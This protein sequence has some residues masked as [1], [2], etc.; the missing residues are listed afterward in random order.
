MNE[1]D[2]DATATRDGEEKIREHVRNAQDARLPG[3]NGSNITLRRYDWFWP[4]H[5]P[6]GKTSEV[7]GDPAVYKTGTTLY[8]CACVTTGAPFPN[9]PATARR[10]PGKVLFFSAE[11]DDHDTLLPRFLAAGGDRKKIHFVTPVDDLPSLPEDAPKLREWIKAWEPLLVVFDP[12]DAFFGK[13]VDAN[14]NPDVRRALRPL[15]RLGSQTHTTFLLIRHLNKDVKLGRAMYRAAGS[16]GTTAT[17]RASYILGPQRDDPSTYIFACNK[18]NGAPKPRSLGY[19]IVGHVLKG[20]EKD[21]VT[22]R[23]EWLGETDQ[24]ADDLVREPEPG[25][26]GPKPE[27]S[28]SAESIIKQELADGQWHPS[29]PIIELAKKRGIGYRTVVS[30]A[31]ALKV[32]MKKVGFNPTRWDWHLPKAQ[33]TP[34]SPETTNNSATSTKPNRDKGSIEDAVLHTDSGNSA[35][36]T[37]PH[38]Q[39]DFTEDAELSPNNNSATSAKAFSPDGFNHSEEAGNPEDAEFRDSLE[40]GHQ[41]SGPDPSTDG[42]PAFPTHALKAC[43]RELGYSAREIERISAAEGH[44]IVNGRLREL[45]LS[46]L[47]IRTMTFDQKLAAIRGAQVPPDTD[48]EGDWY[49]LDGEE[50]K[51]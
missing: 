48:P 15:V 21:V 5:I 16:I 1:D 26:R 46:D 27:K 51:Q 28:E 19:R 42:I 9:E 24:T 35:T 22:Q 13:K 34:T 8:L 44:R 10:E 31:K 12:L 18:L 2:S 41:K 25:P 37:N 47:D 49:G 14:S 3:R 17:T 6:K 4:D 45:G 38:G 29:K 40:N 36:S 43:L 23:V 50:I 7:C 32:E 30:V 33:E 11:D 20:F 39:N